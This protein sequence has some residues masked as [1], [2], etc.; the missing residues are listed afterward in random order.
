ML[1]VGS[2]KKLE[3][4]NK[5]VLVRFDLNIPLDDVSGKV[6]D[7]LTRIKSTIN[8]LQAL[9]S[10][11][12]ILSHLGRPKGVINQDLSLKKIIGQLEE[13]LNSKV[14]FIN[15]C[16]GEEVKKKINSFDQS[17]IIL[18]ENCRFHKGEEENNL[19]F[20]KKLSEL[21]DVYINDAFGCVHRSHASVDA[22]TKYMPSYVGNLLD[23]EIKNLHNITDKPASP[24]I[25]ILGGSKI[26]TKISVLKNLSIKMDS[27][28][29]C[30]GM[31]NNFLAYNGH[32]VKNSLI[33][34]DVDNLVQEIISY[35]EKNKCNL[36]T[37]I[38][39]VT[40]SEIRENTE[41]YISPIDQIKDGNMILDIGPKTIDLIKNELDKS[42]SVFWNGPAGVFE[43]KPFDN[44]TNQ[45]ATLIAKKS[46]NK[47]IQSFAGGGDTIAALELA[48]VKNKFSYV[49][50]GGGALL[51]LLEGK[52]LPG[53]V[54][55]GIIK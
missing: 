18:L 32:D 24:S 13:V 34:K 17:S 6:N 42:K 35:A 20:A 8:Q 19:E 53:L 29:I 9:N 39:V 21:A 51:E 47:L 46:I 27:I 37:P 43:T 25:T 28:V 38:D 12:I 5:T 15:D 1:D 45:I 52:K 44:G 30:G 49:S 33:E 48:E 3:D 7:R 4:R 10:K 31:A 14:N 50:T 23:E 22:I 55:L 2:I 41:I 16:I 40:A 26:S 11:I 54:A 36:I